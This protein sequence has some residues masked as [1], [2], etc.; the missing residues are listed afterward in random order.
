MWRRG[1]GEG[2]GGREGGCFVFLFLSWTNR[3]IWMKIG[4]SLPKL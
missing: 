2:K 1:Q 4:L 3:A